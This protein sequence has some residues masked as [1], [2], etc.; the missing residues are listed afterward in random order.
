VSLADRRYGGGETCATGCAHTKAVAALAPVTPRPWQTP[1]TPRS[2]RPSPSPA[3][4]KQTATPGAAAEVTGLVSSFKNK[5]C[6][7]CK[8]VH[9]SSK[10]LFYHWHRC[11]VCETIY[12]P[13]CGG[14]LSN[15]RKQGWTDKERDCDRKLC[16][17]RTA[18]I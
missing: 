6:F 3:Q 5:T 18:L 4:R 9:G 12:C 14:K 7:K 11:R 2:R 1:H 17:G 8:A 16:T 13:T 15:I 10:S